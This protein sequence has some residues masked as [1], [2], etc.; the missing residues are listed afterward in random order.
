MRLKRSILVLSFLLLVAACSGGQNPFFTEY[1]TPFGVPPFG[2]IEEK[3]FMPAFEEGMKRQAAEIEE[4]AANREKPTF[5]NTV[6]AVEYS[7]DL[8]RKVSDVFFS[9]NSAVTSDGMQQIARDVSP[10]LSSHRDDILLNEQLF[11]RF[12]TLYEKKDDPGLDKEQSKLLEEYYKDF[13]RN[14]A[15]LPEAD[16]ERLREINKQLS[17]LS[18]RFGENVLKATNS[19]EMV[20]DGEEDL[21]GL[22]EWVRTGAAEAAAEKGYEGKWLFTIQKPSMVPFLQ[23]SQKRDLREKIFKA[24]IDRCDGGELDNR[25]HVK[26]IIA[27]R[28]EKAALMGFATYADF[29]LDEAMAK[30]PGKVY[31]LLDQLWKPALLKAK[32]EASLLQ[33]MVYREGDDF[34]IEPW[35]WWYYAEKLKKEQYDLDDEILKPYFPLDSVLEG[36]FTVV[37]RLYGITFEER[38]D[39]PLYHEEARVFEVKEEDG[40]HVGLFYTDYFPRESKRGGAWMGSFRKQYRDERGEMVT[41]IIYNVG[42][43]S[44][45]AGEMPSLLNFDEVH[46]LFHELGHGLHGL[47]SDGTYPTLTGTAVATDFVELPSQIME[48]WATDPAVLKMY[49]R[50]YRTGEP[51]PDELIEKIKKSKYF[52]QGFAATEYLAASYLDMDWHTR[53]SGTG[54]DVNQFEDAA[55]D[56]IGMI[57]EIVVRYRTPYFRHIFASG[58]A[59]GYYSYIW[60]EVLDADAFEAFRERGIFDRKTAEDF[61]RYILAM[62]GAG[63]PMEQYIQFRGRE[64]EIEP[65]L[66][67]RGLD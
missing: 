44:K 58:Y 26:Q 25:E 31:E 41:P 29:A 8:L 63:D 1:D 9:L 17:L 18:I 46:T 36:A 32:E 28:Q 67:R 15:G 3:H 39:I 57:P 64:P 5:E 2:K 10:M 24:Y 66:K 55:M 35:D 19:F 45:P 50:H 16:K 62:G 6:E 11:E 13:V 56:R 12:K 52:N 30:E 59:A 37:K 65:L 60:A 48:N 14:G 4:I 49:A 40:T 21:A 54:V 34:E 22:P 47:L 51:I 42:N 27:L 7:G 23:Y 61:R 33:A 20:L 53:S 38:T 43:F